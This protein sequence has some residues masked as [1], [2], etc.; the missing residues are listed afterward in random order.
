MAYEPLERLVG[1]NPMI[2]GLGD[3]T[4]HPLG[5]AQPTSQSHILT[6]THSIGQIATHDPD[7]W[8]FSGPC[9]CILWRLRS[10]PCVTTH[11]WNVECQLICI[12]VG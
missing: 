10:R 8:L 9:I 3:G 4:T 11:L 5:H 1:A 6:S 12:L 7:L 2:I